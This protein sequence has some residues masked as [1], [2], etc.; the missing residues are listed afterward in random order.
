[1]C[2]PDTRETGD[3]MRSRIAC[4]QE[5]FPAHGTF[6]FPKQA[7]F[8]MEIHGFRE[9]VMTTSETLSAWGVPPDL[10]E[11]LLPCHVVAR[12][13]KGKPDFFKLTNVSSTHQKT[14]TVLYENG[15]FRRMLL[16]R[17]KIALK[18]E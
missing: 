6:V 9:F 7:N 17:K 5:F 18:E 4:A 12:F 14:A 8:P 3:C 2:A 16:H 13:D 1:M 15:K 10:L 11:E